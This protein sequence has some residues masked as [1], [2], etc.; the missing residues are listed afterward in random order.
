MIISAEVFLRKGRKMNRIDS[1]ANEK[2]KLAVKIAGDASRRKKE[3]LFFLEGLR[4]CR[5]AALTGSPIHTAFFTDSAL[6]KNGDDIAFIAERAQRAFLVSDAVGEKLA[7]TGSSQGIFCLCEIPERSREKALDPTGAYIALENIQDPANL[8]AVCRTAEALGI[9]GAVVC[10]GCDIYSPKAQRA[11]MGSLLRLPIFTTDDLCE[12]L[13]SCRERGM[14]L[15]AATPD[16]TAAKITEIDMNGG[17]IAVIGNEGNGVSE[18][19]LSLCRPMTIP[20]LGR[21]ESLNASMAAA[22]TMWEMM[23]PGRQD[24]NGQ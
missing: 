24:D 1:P 12:T 14:K 5:D 20:M 15:F 23:R 16:S 22:I 21:A 9:S 6:R 8:G 11:A 10:G 17:V 4:L 13:L 19:I 7:C 3:K 18:E 2:I